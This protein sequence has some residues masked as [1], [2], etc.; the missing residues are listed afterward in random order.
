MKKLV[1]LKRPVRTKPFPVWPVYDKLEQKA[2]ENTLKSNK[3]GCIDGNKVSEF[4][5]KFA[6]F[7]NA[8][9]G[10]CVNSGTK[11]LEIALKALGIKSGDEVIVPAYTFIATAYA[12]A[13]VGATPV[14]VDI[15]N[16]SYNISP[17]EIEKAITKKTKAIIPV[18]FGGMPADMDSILKIAKKHNLFILEDAAQAHGSEYKGKKVG[19]IG[20]I[21]I[22]SFQSSKNMTC[23][24]GGIILTNNETLAKKCKS[25]V[26]CGRKEGEP[27]YMHYTLGG[28]SRLTEFQAAILLAQLTRVKKHNE[29]R[30]KNAKLLTEK[31]KQIKGIEPLERDKNVTTNSY[32]LYIFKYKSKYF[33]G[34]PR[35]KF[36]KALNEEGIPASGGYI[37]PL[38]RQPAFN[39]KIGETADFSLRYSQIHLPAC[40]Q[41]CKE[42]VWL[43]HYVLLGDKKDVE[44]IV[45][46]IKKIQKHI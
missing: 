31:L 34:I 21:S 22:F 7:H 25:L 3:W 20:D 39:S 18:Y 28:N 36:I 1:G 23:G 46:A 14:F 16:N 33:N 17:I 45:E 43:P 6:N 32:H 30:E 19:T 42:A 40:E 5:K 8:K 27:W 24:E 41:A 35:D 44:D 11:A 29:I 9:F 10:I 37:M 13:E 26:N 38:T 4:E 12:V 15:D 2:L